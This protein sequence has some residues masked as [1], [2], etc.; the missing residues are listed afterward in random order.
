MTYFDEVLI[1]SVQKNGLKNSK[2]NKKEVVFV[3]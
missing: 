1:C 2:T 3:I